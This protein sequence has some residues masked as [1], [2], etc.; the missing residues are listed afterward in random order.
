[1]A[2]TA[3][4]SVEMAEADFEFY[5]PEFVALLEHFSV[6]AVAVETLTLCPG[7]IKNKCSLISQKSINSD[8]QTL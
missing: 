4:A 1:M 2:L 7:K 5:E 6:D 3:V 8:R